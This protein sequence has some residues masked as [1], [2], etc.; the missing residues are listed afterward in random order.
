MGMQYGLS[1]VIFGDDKLES[2]VVKMGDGLT[3]IASVKFENGDCGI[4]FVRA[5]D[6]GKPFQIF[7][8]GESNKVVNERTDEEKVYLIFDDERSID[9]IENQLREA[10]RLLTERG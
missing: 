5:E 1:S 7:D 2:K 3:R 8:E 9:A 6:I 4:C 10:R